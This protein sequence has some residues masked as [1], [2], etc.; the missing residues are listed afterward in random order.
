MEQPLIDTKALFAP[1]KGKQATKGQKQ[2]SVDNKATLKFYSIMAITSLALRL[3]F[4]TTNRL[5]IFLS[6]FAVSTQLCAIAGLK[7][8]AGSTDAPE[9]G[10]DLNLKGGFADYIKDLIITTTFCASTSAYSNVFWLLWLWLPAFYTYKIWVSMIAPWIFAPAPEE[11]APE[12]SEKKR[13]KM[14]RKMARAGYR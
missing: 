1:K 9:G 10:I 7:Y 6:I 12:V 4:S 8:M 14:E 5:D 3:A 13:K 11:L 2:I